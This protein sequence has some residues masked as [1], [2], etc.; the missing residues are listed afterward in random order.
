[1]SV[2]SQQPAHRDIAEPILW[3]WRA[4]LRFAGAIDVGCGDGYFSLAMAE[5]G[6]FRHS[7]I[8]NIDAQP[9]FSDT[10]SAIHQA[11]GGHFRICAVGERDGGT[12]ELLR[13]QHPYW[14]S[15]RP[16]GDRYWAAVNEMREKTSVQVPLRTID[17]LVE[18][19]GT[20]GPYLLKLDVQGAE[21][22]ALLG[23]RRTLA[24]TSVV[25]VEALMEDF[26]AIHDLLARAGFD[27]FD[28]AAL[29][30]VNDGALGWFYP[31]YLNARHRG[32]RQAGH[33]DPALNAAALT[34]QAQ[35]RD[36]I[37]GL[38]EASLARLRA[39]AWRPVPG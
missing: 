39:D 7:T 13:G 37:H 6:P 10:L 33:W 28:L 1:M 22:E 4:G 9:D 30:Y 17:A 15:V 23:A 2:Q 20:P 16:V 27:L 12:I 32:I 19:T 3:L 21:C 25:L 31:V 35:H 18:E 5:M 24:D 38:I 11:V 8:L 36:Q 34:L 14:S 26:T 29:S